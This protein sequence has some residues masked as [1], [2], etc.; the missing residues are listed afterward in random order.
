M[1]TR[2]Q[3][4][5]TDNIVALPGE[6]LQIEVQ[7]FNCASPSGVTHIAATVV[8]TGEV[9]NLYDD[10]MGD[11]EQA[12]DGIYSGSW[13]VPY[14]EFEY[15]LSTGFDSVKEANDEL[16]VTAAII[17]DNTDETDWTGK[18]WPSVYRADYYGS[19]YRYATENDPEKLFLWSPTVNE[20]NQYRVYARWP[21]G[22]NFAT[23]ATYRISHHDPVD[24]S[25]LMTEVQVD[26]TTNGGVW[27]DMGTYWFNAGTQSIELTNLNADGTVVAD[28]VL[29]VPEL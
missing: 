20:A 6:T 1:F 13:I 12:G 8:P 9:F 25:L 17:V 28:A 15:T 5:K 19:N 23:N 18:W 26:Q 21:D 10:G 4:P 11:D 2:R 27:M 14:G 24:G 7:S 3:A 16:R 29:L 22:P